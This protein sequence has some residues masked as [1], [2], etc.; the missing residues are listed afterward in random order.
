MTIENVSSY[1][2]NNGLGASGSSYDFEPLPRAADSSNSQRFYYQPAAS[3]SSTS[4]QAPQ[5]YFVPD[6]FP[7]TSNQLS[8]LECNTHVPAATPS[9]SLVPWTDEW[10]L[11]LAYIIRRSKHLQR[12][13]NLFA[14][15]PAGSGYQYRGHLGN[16]R[17]APGEHGQ[18]IRS[19]SSY[20]EARYKPYPSH[21][22]F[23]IGS[24]T[25]ADNLG[26]GQPSLR[27]FSDP[28]TDFEQ[29]LYPSTTHSEDVY[30]VERSEE[31][32]KEKEPEEVEEAKETKNTPSAEKA[33][34]S[35]LTLDQFKALGVK[36]TNLG[37]L[38]GAQFSGIVAKKY[39]T[40]TNRA[41]D[42]GHKEIL[43]KAIEAAW[44]KEVANIETGIKT[45][46]DNFGN[47]PEKWVIY[48]LTTIIGALSRQANKRIVCLSELPL[49]WSLPRKNETGLKLALDVDEKQR[50]KNPAVL[51]KCDS[52]SSPFTLTGMID[53]MVI[54]LEEGR[55]DEDSRKTMRGCRTIDEVF[56]QGNLKK[57]RDTRLVLIEAKAFKHADDLDHQRKCG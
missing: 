46:V 23:Q 40:L 4:S 52:A 32:E 37:I 13:L 28:H 56:V 10:V 11:S 6:I 19:T 14:T 20:S 30:A 38:T 54:T 50:M 7:S 34:F 53:I 42:L 43:D 47:N 21:H 22:T 8:T 1:S 29:G 57:Y 27:S 25:P 24:H 44:T 2:T 5:S 41:Q 12:E 36:S 16:N 55:V 49:S 3:T 9:S 18:A 35:T 17:L 33:G 51:L 39:M 45:A 31:V 15:A 48:V 26:W